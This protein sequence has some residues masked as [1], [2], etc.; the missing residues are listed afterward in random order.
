MNKSLI[1]LGTLAAVALVAAPA[2]ADLQLDITG[3]PGSGV[4]T[5]TFSGTGT[6]TGASTVRDNTGTTWNTGDTT[7][8]GGGDGILDAALQDTLLSFTGAATLTV[9]SVTE[10]ITGVFL[11]DD[12][13]GAGDDLG[14]R[15]ANP[16]TY[17]S[18]EA[19]S[20]TGSGTVAVDI[21]QFVLGSFD[22]DFGALWLLDGDAT[23][24]NISLIP[25]PGAL[26]LLGFAG[27][28]ARRRRRG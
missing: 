27:L 7:Q 1:S 9:G 24:V 25:A 23:N 6:T 11:D 17:A 20:W 18:G 16:I 5:W 3:A 21:N 2:S 19:V 10:S 8:F 22:M 12:G 14:V 28:A 4:T 15:V 13:T 26:A